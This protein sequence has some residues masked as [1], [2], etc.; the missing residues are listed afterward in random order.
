MSEEGNHRIQKFGSTGNFSRTWGV[1]GSGDGEFD[2]PWDVAVDTSGNVYVA[3]TIND[4]IQKFS[5]NGN[6]IGSWVSFGSGDGFH[7]PARVALD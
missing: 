2:T 1:H 3:D 5:S 4:R 7:H 6:F